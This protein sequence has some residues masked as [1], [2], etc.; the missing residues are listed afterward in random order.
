MKKAE[1]I[2]TIAMIGAGCMGCGIAQVFAL[3]GFQVRLSEHNPQ[4]LT[5]AKS[6]IRDDLAYQV[7]KKYIK[8]EDQ[9]KALARIDLLSSHQSFKNYDLVIEAIAENEEEKCALWRDLAPHLGPETILASA[10]SGVSITRLGAASGH[11]EHFIGLHFMNPAPAMKLVE[12]VRGIATDPSIITICRD[13]VT[14]INKV[15]IMSEDFPAFI[16]NRIL[17]TM[18]NEAIHTLYEGVGSV[19]SIDSAMRFG[20]NHPMGPLALA[21]FMGL[22][23]CLHSIETVHKELADNKYRPCPLLVKYVEAGWLGVRSGRGFYDY[24][25]ET[26]TPTR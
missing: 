12:I 13:L 21:D 10:T 7:A 18:I 25:G 20:A 15:S 19:E 24:S 5:A 11:P 3:N 4:R 22:D 6:L 1:T 23:V 9:K 8:P 14:R 2:S 17:L 16:V 26:P